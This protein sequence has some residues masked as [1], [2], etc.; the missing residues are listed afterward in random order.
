M[1]SAKYQSIFK[2]IFPNYKKGELTPPIDKSRFEMMLN[3]LESGKFY[4]NDFGK[5]LL[6]NIKQGYFEFND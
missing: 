4:R 2:E 1:H 5:F 6:D 3:N